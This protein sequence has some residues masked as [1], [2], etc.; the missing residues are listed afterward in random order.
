MPFITCVNRPKAAPLSGALTLG[1]FLFALCALSLSA[2]APARAAE[3]DYVGYAWETGGL[4]SSQPGD[5]LAIAT[6]VTQI[7]ALFGV[8][9]SS[10]EGTLYIDGL[11]SLG[12]TLDEPT[13]ATVISYSGGTI[14]VHADGVRNSDWGVN[15]ANATVPST[16]TDGSLIFSGVFT[17]F[18]VRMLASGLGI[19]EGQID[20]TGGSALGGPCANCAYTF[21]GTFSEPTGAN[22]PLGYDVQCDGI[23]TVESAIATETINWGSLKQLYNPD[24]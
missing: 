17:S 3:V 21:S 15:P 24:R 7:D 18:T 4:A 16:F 8:D 9:L 23:L 13:G 1:L 22:I 6:V 5:Q 12:S 20:G 10:Q 14:T 2:V 11:T 19:F